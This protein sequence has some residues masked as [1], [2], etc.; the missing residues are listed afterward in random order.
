MAYVEKGA[1]AIG[2]AIEVDIRGKR[3]PAT[4]VAL[5]FYRRTT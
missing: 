2:Q 5:P 1:A 4:I 3:E